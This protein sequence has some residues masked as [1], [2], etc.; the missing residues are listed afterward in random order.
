MFQVPGLMPNLIRTMNPSK[1]LA[2]I[3]CYS[4]IVL[5]ELPSLG[6]D[7]FSHTT[8]IF[9]SHG[10]ALHR[11]EMSRPHIALIA[12]DPDYERNSLE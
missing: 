2:I 1:A 12:A 8:M 6:T 7:N 11:K 10:R 9:S 4:A 5:I 3:S